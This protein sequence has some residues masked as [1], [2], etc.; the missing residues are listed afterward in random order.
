M[1]EEAADT[2]RPIEVQTPFPGLL[3]PCLFL[4]LLGL[5]GSALLNSA[6][7][8][9]HGNRLIWS[10]PRLHPL[11]QV[12]AEDA[13]PHSRSAGQPRGEVHA[14]ADLTGELHVDWPGLKY[15]T[16]TAQLCLQSPVGSAGL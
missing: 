14:V 1:P 15:Q 12:V 9:C 11:A 7:P 3:Y 4:L 2:G 10:N 5:L 13:L 6:S 8:H 16:A